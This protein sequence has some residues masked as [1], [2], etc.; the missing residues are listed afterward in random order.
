MKKIENSFSDIE[1]LNITKTRQN[2]DSCGTGNCSS[3]ETV[4]MK[5][6]FK[7]FFDCDRELHKAYSI[8][9]I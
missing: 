4:C 3:I 8:E 7:L 9:D 6:Q 5:Q 2:I 1:D